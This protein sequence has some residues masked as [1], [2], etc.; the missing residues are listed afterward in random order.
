MIVKATT[1]VVNTAQ[2]VTDGVME[3]GTVV[4]IATGVV[5]IATQATLRKKWLL[6]LFACILLLATGYLLLHIYW[7]PVY[8]LRWLV[9]PSLNI[10]YLLVMLWRN[11]ED[12]KRHG[13]DRLLPTLGWGN[14]L[15]LTRGLLVAGM[16][17]FLFLPQ[18]LGWLAWLPGILYMLSDAADFFDGYVAR[19]MNHV[20]H[21]GQILDMSLDGVG[22]LAAC[23]LAVH[24]GQAPT[25]YIL[26]G[27]C[28]YLFLGGLWLRKRL[29]LPT[30]DLPPSLSR[31]IFAGLQM[32]FLAVIL[33]PLFSPPGTTIAATLFGLP[34]LVGFMRDWLCASG[35]LKPHRSLSGASD[36]WPASL[37]SRWLP[38]GLRLAILIILAGMLLTNSHP[39]ISQGLPLA[40]QPLVV[41]MSGVVSLFAATLLIL[42]LVPRTGAIL[43]LVTL[44]FQQILAP[45]ELTQVVLAV[46]YTAIL[47]IGG[48]DFSLWRPDDY[49]F[50]HRAGEPRLQPSLLEV[51]VEQGK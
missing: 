33:W 46:A 20:T 11:L 1:G 35:A 7:Q 38:L 5:A 26:I 9:L 30:Y 31:R 23:L 13:E 10:A 37:L 22:M 3:T 42:G 28:R 25:W 4:E 32:G 12:N 8:A 2:V 29:G 41:I 17:G 39:G 16:L 43:G 51:S 27:L 15:T 14:T 45:L 49:L 36:I 48:G 34:L 50:F 19:R 24:Y 18:P 44:G 6:F 21:L 47:Y 40:D